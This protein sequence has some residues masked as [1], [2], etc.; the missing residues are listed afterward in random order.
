MFRNLFQDN[1]LVQFGLHS[2]FKAGFLTACQCGVLL[3]FNKH[4]Q[5]VALADM[6][7]SLKPRLANP[8]GQGF[9]SMYLAR[10]RMH[11]HWRESQSRGPFFGLIFDWSR[12]FKK[13]KIVSKKPDI[14]FLAGSNIQYDG[15]KLG[16]IKAVWSTS[17]GLRL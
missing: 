11:T 3:N 17:K 14:S 9:K 12:A 10:L 13:D 15:V 1:D 5:V 8:F 7:S 2:Q 6:D 4:C 16:M